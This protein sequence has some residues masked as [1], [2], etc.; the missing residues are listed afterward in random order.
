[1]AAANDLYTKRLYNND[2]SV[3]A[4]TDS[5]TTLEV[6]C[7][8]GSVNIDGTKSLN[9]GY[10]LPKPI[11][12]TVGEKVKLEA[13]TFGEGAKYLNGITIKSNDGSVCDVI[14]YRY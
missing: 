5:I 11:F 13:K 6:R 1:M 4:T 10:Y 8:A 7:V 12:L 14:A 2:S 9:S 3:I